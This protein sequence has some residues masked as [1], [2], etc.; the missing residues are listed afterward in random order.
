MKSL[1]KKYR[2]FKAYSDFH[3][4]Q[5]SKTRVVIGEFG[6]YHS[7]GDVDED[8]IMSYCTQ[9]NI[10]YMGWFWKGN[11]GGGEYLDIANQWDSSQLSSDWGEKLI[12]GTNGIRKTSKIC[13]VFGN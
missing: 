1:T 9:K 6:Q 12:N 11:S 13:Y 3:S 10:G 8:Y 2:H 5:L 4:V 7:D